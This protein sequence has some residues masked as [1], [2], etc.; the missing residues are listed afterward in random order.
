V[1]G[2]VFFDN[3][4]EVAREQTG[5]N[6]PVVIE[7]I[8]SFNATYHKFDEGSKK[9]V[10]VKVAVQRRLVEKFVKH[11]SDEAYDLLKALLWCAM[12]GCE[13]GYLRFCADKYPG[14]PFIGLDYN[15]CWMLSDEEPGKPRINLTCYP[16]AMPWNP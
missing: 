6:L 5:C 13:Y 14:Q 12:S 16:Q 2:Q 4:L 3:A 7:D 10:A 15:G 1:N 11:G 8:P 9:H